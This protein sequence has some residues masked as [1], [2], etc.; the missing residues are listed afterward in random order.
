MNA[1]FAM[2]KSPSKNIG[3]ALAL[4]ISRVHLGV[5]EECEYGIAWMGMGLINQIHWLAQLN[6]NSLTSHHFPLLVG[7]FNPS[8]KML[9]S[10]GLSCPIDVE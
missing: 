2:V 1:L 7:G 6:T 5:Y 10:W 4:F 8:E 9:V 3:P